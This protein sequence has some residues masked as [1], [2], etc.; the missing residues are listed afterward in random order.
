MDVDEMA[1]EL[2]ANHPAGESRGES[3]SLGN[4]GPFPA[5][6]EGSPKVTT[7]YRA[8]PYISEGDGAR[9]RNHRIDSPVL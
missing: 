9:T 7:D 2:W 4:I 5:G 1:D 6:N 3:K 8:L